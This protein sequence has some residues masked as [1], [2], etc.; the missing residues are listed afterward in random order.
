MVHHGL[1][2]VHL[3]NAP[4]FECG[5]CLAVSVRGLVWAGWF[6]VD[7]DFSHGW[8]VHDSFI[9]LY[10]FLLCGVHVVV[11]PEGPFQGVAPGAWLDPRPWAC[12]SAW[13]W[14]VVSFP[15]YAG[16]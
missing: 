5:D 11:F 9:S 12:M 13:V 7:D 6:V 16:M 14:G 15:A 2:C 1:G 10:Q 4:V 8:G 3:V